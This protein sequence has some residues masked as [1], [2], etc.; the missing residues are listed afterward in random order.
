MKIYVKSAIFLIFISNIF[1]L[2]NLNQ[3]LMQSKN[4]IGLYYITYTINIPIIPWI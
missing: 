4:K 1:L 3:N 2:T